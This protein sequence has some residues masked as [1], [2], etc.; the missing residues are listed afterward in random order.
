[1]IVLARLALLESARRTEI[2]E[3]RGLARI[4]VFRSRLPMMHRDGWAGPRASS[5]MPFAW[6]SWQRGHNA[7][8]IVDRI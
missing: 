3:R 2:L 4:H 1:V 5:S 6:F 7:P 8:T